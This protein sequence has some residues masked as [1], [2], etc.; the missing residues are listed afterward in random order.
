[1]HHY[2]IQGYTH[3]HTQKTNYLNI[4]FLNDFNFQCPNSSN[5]FCMSY[6][7]GVRNSPSVL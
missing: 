7:N 2:I 3:T 6:N 1:M 4:T 5:N